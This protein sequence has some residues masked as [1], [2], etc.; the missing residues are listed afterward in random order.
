MGDAGATGGLR[1]DADSGAGDE[2]IHG[3]DGWV[4]NRE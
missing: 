1:V 4:H 2:A 3:D